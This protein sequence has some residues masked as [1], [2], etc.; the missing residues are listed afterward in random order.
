MLDCSSVKHV[1]TTSIQALIDTRNQL[2]R[3][4]YP[5]PVEWHLSHISNRWTRRALAS[6]GF[7]YPSHAILE[8]NPAWKPAYTVASVDPTGD[9]EK[10]SSVIHT[11]DV[12]S[13]DIDRISSGSKSGRAGDRVPDRVAALQGVNRPF[14]HLDVGAAVEAAIANIETKRG[15]YPIATR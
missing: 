13:D 3:H 11:K 8:A 5:D 7:G 4:A 15:R 10:Q 1:D 9:Y 2:D 12:D 14:F 6:A